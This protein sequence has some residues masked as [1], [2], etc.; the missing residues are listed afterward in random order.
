MNFHLSFFLFVFRI[1]VVLK[2]MM[3][4]DKNLPYIRN[5]KNE[6]KTTKHKQIVTKEVGFSSAF[7][8]KTVFL[9]LEI[10]KSIWILVFQHLFARHPRKRV[11]IFSKTHIFLNFSLPFVVRIIFTSPAIE[12]NL[13]KMK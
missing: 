8:N 4:N 5:G 13:H 7:G 9:F 1:L 11:V 2:I 3:K 10:S 6:K 12:I